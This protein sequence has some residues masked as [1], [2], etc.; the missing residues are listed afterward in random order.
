MNT[1]VRSTTPVE[2]VKT[3]SGL[4]LLQRLQ[5]RP[6]LIGLQPELF[7]DNGP[8]PGDVIEVNEKSVCIK[9]ILLTQWITRFILPPKWKE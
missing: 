2:V 1:T 6:K 7:G 9:T 4:D 5:A 8:Q 3:E